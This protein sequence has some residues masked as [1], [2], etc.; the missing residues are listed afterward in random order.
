MNIDIPY[1]FA[2][3]AGP[4]WVPGPD[5]SATPWAWLIV[6]AAGGVGACL[7]RNT[8]KSEHGAGR[9]RDANIGAIVTVLVCSV[10]ALF[11]LIVAGWSARIADQQPGPWWPFTRFDRVDHLNSQQAAAY[12]EQH[13]VDTSKPQVDA[14]ALDQRLRSAITATY[15][16]T[17]VTST[18]LSIEQPFVATVNGVTRECTTQVTGQTT[19]TLNRPARQQ[20][21]VLCG[22]TEPTRRT[23]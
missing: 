15:T 11:I 21:T 20:V 6:L 16:I 13:S 2:A 10:S 12:L 14:H 5:L 17:V 19:D 1:A 4:L 23:S 9:P 18:P 22:G 7:I 8:W 3:P